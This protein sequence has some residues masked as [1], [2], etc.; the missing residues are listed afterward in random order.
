[1]Y[2]F[3]RDHPKLRRAFI[4]GFSADGPLAALI[5]VGIALGLVAVVSAMIA[6]YLGN[7]LLDDLYLGPILWRSLSSEC[8]WL[9]VLGS[10]QWLILGGTAIATGIAYMALDRLSSRLAWRCTRWRRRLTRIA[11]HILV[12]PCATVAAILSATQL[13]NPWV[14]TWEQFVTV[15]AGPLAV[16]LMVRARRTA[17]M[18]CA[19]MNPGQAIVATVRSYV[20][21]DVSLPTEGDVMVTLRENRLLVEAP[22]DGAEAERVTDLVRLHFPH[23]TIIVVRS[24]VADQLEQRNLLRPSGYERHRLET[25]EARTRMYVKSI[26]AVSIVSVV[27]MLVLVAMFPNVAML[28]GEQIRTALQSSGSRPVGLYWG[29]P[30]E[31]NHWLIDLS[32][33]AAQ[34]PRILQEAEERWMTSFELLG[35]MDRTGMPVKRIHRVNEMFILFEIDPESTTCVRESEWPT[36][37]GARFAARVYYGPQLWEQVS[38]GLD[39]RWSPPVALAEPGKLQ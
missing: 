3:V 24:T 21:Y 20:R 4:L 23:V 1:M 30:R 25:S 8:T 14:T 32:G 26:A 33:S 17:A 39:W 11:P 38:P 34:C 12:Y 10:F 37:E 16:F 15:M 2:N 6:W 35:I 29:L 31:V 36:L 7:C 19:R 28:T 13:T 5:G 22:I 18:A 9:P 27:V